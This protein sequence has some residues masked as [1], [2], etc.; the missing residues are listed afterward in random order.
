MKSKSMMS[1]FHF[2]ILI[3]FDICLISLTHSILF[4]ESIVGFIFL[5]NIL[6]FLLVSKSKSYGFAVAYIGKMI[7]II[8]SNEILFNVSLL[9]KLVTWTGFYFLYAYH[10]ILEISEAYYNPNYSR[11]D[12]F[13]KNNQ[14][15][16]MF[17][18]ETFSSFVITN[19]SQGGF[20]AKGEVDSKYLQSLQGFKVQVGD[21]LYSLN[22]RIIKRESGGFGVKVVK[23][24][25]WDKLYSKVEKLN[26]VGFS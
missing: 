11:Y 12:L 23:S 26:I 24:E 22:G 2:F 7:F 9:L 15:A 17:D 18:Q 21:S 13:V 19:M 1:F 5:T 8:F 10:F 3:L 14:I 4:L 6:I 25:N 20:F 16:L